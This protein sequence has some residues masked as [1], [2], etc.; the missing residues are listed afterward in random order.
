MTR[1]II[2]K[3]IPA[4]FSQI[5][6]SGLQYCVGDEC[7]LCFLSAPI[8]ESHMLTDLGTLE[9]KECHHSWRLC[10]Y[11]KAVLWRP[12]TPRRYETSRHLGETNWSH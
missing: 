11:E 12:L 9:A 1:R 5:L 10:G 7:T 6:L 4:I 2:S 3:G 8:K